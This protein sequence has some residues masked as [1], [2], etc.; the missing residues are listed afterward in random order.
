MKR[1]G[2]R[3]RLLTATV[4][5]AI[6]VALALAAILLDRQYRGLDEALQARVRADARQLASAAEFGVFSGSRKALQA[7]TRAT[8]AGDP[9]VVAATV[10]DAAGHPLASSGASTLA[11]PPAVSRAERLFQSGS[12]TVAVVPIGRPLLAVDDIYSD[13]GAP[14]AAP[15]IDGYVVIE[16][17]RQHLDAERTRQLLIGVGIALG[18]AL[19]AAWLALGIAAGVIRPILHIGD[20]VDRIGRGDLAARVRPD[21]AAVMPNLEDGINSMAQRI[22][23]AQDSLMQQIDAATAE[24][25]ARKEE[26]ERANAAK[27][28]FVAA[29]SHDLRQ[30]LHA[31]GL[32]VSRLAQLRHGPDVRPLVGHIDASVQALQDLLDTL[33]DIS[34]LDA[35]MV[36][37]KPADFAAAD[38][39]ARLALDHAGPA[40]EKQL[41]LRIRPS[42]LWLQT[43]PGLLLRILVNFVANAL[44]YTTQGGVLVACRRRGDKARLQ[45]WDTGMGIP[46]DHLRDVFSEYVQL[47]N[48]ERNRDKGLGLG[49]AICER[50]SQL[51]DL[52]LGLRSV[53]GRGS[54][55]WVD[56][57]LGR[58]EA[59]A[60]AD[61]P[62][63]MPSGRIDGTVVV[64]ED[65][66][67]NAASM[68]G[69]LSG[70]GCLV[71]GA[72][73]SVEA[74][75]L[76]EEAGKAPDLV[77]S[78]YRL[79]GDE[80]GVAAGMALRRRFG[81][82]PVVLI[83]ADADERLVEGAARRRFTLLTKPVRPGKLRAIV[84]QTL[85][86]SRTT[87]DE[88]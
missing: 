63:A 11:L 57:P 9:D 15:Q 76:C 2:L 25:R 28:R 21:A 31:L 41:R 87:A 19:L 29:A 58:A 70:W 61:V 3:V 77:I 33:L 42:A 73:S 81:P 62:E 67:P 88:G 84:Q 38:L 83:G 54:V 27:T 56:V 60:L 69:L 34:R 47:G 23:L 13:S 43:D 5:P 78:D 50:L 26:A 68:I 86:Q 51:L 71:V 85:A 46:P 65:D 12:I 66:V 32:F 10:L 75:R 14:D 7:M 82:V 45:V 24:L 18:G 16:M 6:V 40:D 35:G 8:L 64:L 36:A 49:L 4:L 44:R 22:G 52:P 59:A 80:D 1:P 39:F 20:V 53:P 55:F 37:V 48:P 17:S 30:P 74:V 79:P 72:A